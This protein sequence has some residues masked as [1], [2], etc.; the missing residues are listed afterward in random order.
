MVISGDIA[1]WES[2][3]SWKD[4]NFTLFI[5]SSPSHSQAMAVVIG[6]VHLLIARDPLLN[7]KHLSSYVN[8]AKDYLK[9]EP[10]SSKSEENVIFLNETN[11][12]RNIRKACEWLAE[13]MTKSIHNSF[14][15]YE[16]IGIHSN[17]QQETS[18]LGIDVEGNVPDE[19]QDM[20]LI[21]LK[22]PPQLLLSERELGGTG[23]DRASSLLN[24]PLLCYSTR[25]VF[26][27][28]FLQSLPPLL[29]INLVSSEMDTM[30]DLVSRDLIQF[31]I[32]YRQ[33]YIRG[34]PK[35]LQQPKYTRDVKYDHMAMVFGNVVMV[36]E[37]WCSGEG[38]MMALAARL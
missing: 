14:P 6:I 3:Y 22:S 21:S 11:R 17:P 15:A 9:L 5:S 27:K 28:P 31:E 35:N 25:W 36:A 18:K 4:W 26:E 29:R 2:F 30:V 24:F 8:H 1:I 34:I 33:A 7:H 23:K 12:E 20:V 37:R 10:D 19:I 32:A 13:H 16:G 38:T